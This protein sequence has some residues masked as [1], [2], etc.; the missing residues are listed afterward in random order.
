M[1]KLLTFIIAFVLITSCVPKKKYTQVTKTDTNGYTYES[2]TNDPY[3]LRIYTLENGLKAYLSV[4]K[5]E[6]RIQTFI[7]VKAGS[8]YDPA[9]NTGLAHYLEHMMFKGSPKFGTIDWEKEKVLLDEISDLY[10]KHKAE[11]D[12]AKKKE[13][14]S[15]IDKTSQEAAQYVAPNEYDQLISSIGGKYTNAYTTNERTVYMN[16][17]P[18]NELDKWLQIESERFFNL[19]L[20]VFHTELETVYE[21]FNMGQDRDGTKAYFALLSELFPNHP[22]GQQ[23]TIGKAE[24]LKNPSMENIRKYWSTYYVPNNMAICLSGDFNPEKT[25]QLIDKYFGKEPSKE[26]EPVVTPKEEPITEVKETEVFGPEQEFMMLAYRF[27]GTTSR[28]KKMVTLID[29]LLNNS[30]AG[31]IDLNLNQQQ[32][33]LKAG[34]GPNFMKE[35]GFHIFNG[36]PRQ[37]QSLEEVRD[38]ILGEIEKIKKGEF[39][40]WLIEASINNMKLE[41]IKSQENN[42]R[43]HKFAV[44]F[45]DGVN[46]V[47]YLNFNEELSTLTKEE[48]IAFANEKYTA[49]NYVVIYKRKGEDTNIVKVEKPEI[50]PVDLKRENQST[51]FTTLTSQESERL[52]PVFIDYDQTIVKKELAK[53]V[54]F[55]YIQNPTNEL[56]KLEYI[57]NMGKNH[58]K[59]LALA[60]NYLPFLGTDKY[61]PAEL[62]QE[63]FKYGLEFGVST[64][65]DR[66]YVY[67]NGLEE[68]VDKAIE[69]LEHVLANAVPDADSYKK[70][71]EGIEKKKADNKLDKR[72]ILNQGMMSYAKYGSKSSFT[73]ILS[74]EEMMAIDPSALT[75]KI[76]EITKKEHIIFYYGKKSDKEAFDLLKNKHII[77]AELQAIPEP[78]NYAELEISKPQVYFVNYDMVQTQIMMLSKDEVLNNSLTPKARLFNEFY[79]AGLSSIVFQEIRESRALVYSA[80]SYFSTPNRMGDSHY[81]YSFMATQPDKLKAATLAMSDLLSEIPQADKQFEL[82]KQ[83]IMKNIET[84]RIIKDRIFWNYISAKD[85]GLDYDNRKDVYEFMKT[86]T[87][88]EFKEFFNSHINNKQYVYLVI[89]NKDMVD[90]NFLKKLGPIKELTLEEVFNY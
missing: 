75:S 17:I 68:N 42:F 30:Q 57:V 53:G 7:P 56:F 51:F 1:K 65:S 80:Y 39:E 64:T 13:I 87:Q 8:T 49:N 35:Y 86:A 26:I 59:E 90:F 18:S 60:V 69:L 31:L 83:T 73:D 21:E 6:P 43:A 54:G 2:V 45:A 25:I 9:D 85:R 89:G 50:T 76:K 67:I 88:A 82:A 29:Y 14:Y 41:E 3:G 5:D 23:T 36:T 61:S 28:D 74:K 37:D 4:N 63:F 66:S 77:D 19:V 40:D 38:L 72:T 27:D 78:T 52:E 70:Y 62:Q 10:E 84:E 12:P 22:Y 16:N 47:D 48:I 11:I 34:C 46:W 81:N 58:D 20:R 24:H 71:V 79:G 33:V 32:K 55:N 44:T 15:L